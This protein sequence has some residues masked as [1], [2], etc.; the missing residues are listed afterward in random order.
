MREPGVVRVDAPR[1][2]TLRTLTLSEVEALD[3]AVRVAT[4]R[5]VSDVTLPYVGCVVHIVRV[6]G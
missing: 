5:G 2:Y 1:E 3:L 4:V 6:P